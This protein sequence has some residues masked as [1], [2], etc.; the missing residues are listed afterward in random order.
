MAE[1]LRNRGK[2]ER[3]VYEP[4]C[5]C[6]IYRIMNHKPNLYRIQYCSKHEASMVVYEA[7][8]KAYIWMNAFMA[9]GGRTDGF[10]WME[11][12]QALVKAEEK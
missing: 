4:E 9:K 2:K 1:S 11:V 10:P 8:R 5:G 6:E 12:T 7:L 3:L